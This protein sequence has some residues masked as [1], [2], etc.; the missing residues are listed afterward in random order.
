MRDYKRLFLLVWMLMLIIVI[1][2]F[3][4]PVIG[5]ML[6]SILTTFATIIGFITVFFEMKRAADIDECNFVLET[7]KHFTSDNTPGITIVFEK[8]DK[9]FCDGENNITK[10]DRK[11]VVEYLQFFEM[12]AGLIEKDSIAIPDIDRLYGY[13]FFIAVNCKEIQEMELIPYKDFYEGIFNIYSKWVKYRTTNNKSIPFSDT[14]LC[15]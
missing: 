7:Y 9:L 11:Y 3:L 12:L 4:S 6:T 13:Q 5:N 10:D 1:V 14:P 2:Q 8:L 15:K